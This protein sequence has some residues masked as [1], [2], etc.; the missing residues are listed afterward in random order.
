MTLNKCLLLNE[1]SVKDSNCIID[2]YTPL[3]KEIII[4]RKKYGNI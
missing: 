2:D 4:E 1:L 3:I